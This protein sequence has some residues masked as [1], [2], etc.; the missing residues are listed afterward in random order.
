MADLTAFQPRI[1]LKRAARAAWAAENLPAILA[2]RAD[3]LAKAEAAMA[4]AVALGKDVKAQSPLG[5]ATP[6]VKA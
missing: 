6:P 5:R 4:A 1:P 2:A 3:R